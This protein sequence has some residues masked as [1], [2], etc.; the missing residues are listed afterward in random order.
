LTADTSITIPAWRNITL[1]ADADV[2]I[3]RR[4]WHYNY[5][6]EEPFI[7]TL[8]VISNGSTLILIGSEEANLII[9]GGG[10]ADV[11][12]HGPL[13][14][15]QSGGTL[16]MNKNVFLQNNNNQGYT[17][18]GGVNVAFGAEF[19]MNGGTI[20]GNTAYSGGGVYIDYSPDNDPAQFF[21]YGGEISGNKAEKDGNNFGNGGGVFVGTGGTFENDGKSVAGNTPDDVYYF[22][23]APPLPSIRVTFNSNGGT[24]I[25]PQFVTED[26]KVEEPAEP[27]K[28]GYTFEG[29]YGEGF[30]YSWNF[31]LNVAGNIDIN[32]INVVE[33][34]I[35]LYARWE[36]DPDYFKIGDT[37][38]GGGII[39][40]IADGKGNNQYSI[41]MTGTEETCYYLEAAPEDAPGS[42]VQWGYSEV[43]CD[44]G[45]ASYDYMGIGSGRKNTQLIVDALNEAN[46]TGMAAQLC[47][48]ADYGGFH[49]WFLPGYGELILMYQNRNLEGLKLSNNYYWSSSISDDYNAGCINF[50]N[51]WDGNKY[52]AFFTTYN[53]VR[54]TRAF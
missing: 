42:P 2:I 11:I 32:E 38:P 40:Y 9:D 46:V 22:E 5:D 15:V 18:G 24:Y 4:G 53:R 7:E 35:I 49:D 31:S 43:N 33:S 21:M 34:E 16:I 6:G 26:G 51:D 23:E 17:H 10:N 48:N 41:F 3:E 19:I 47:A 1:I 14:S 29:W 36:F 30:D 8:F 50:V 52:D 27:A 13:I 45:W 12:A 44:R 37:G 28:P 25:G 39:F 54:A 20:T